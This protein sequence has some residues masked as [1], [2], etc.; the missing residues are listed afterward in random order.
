MTLNGNA[1][2]NLEIFQT[3][4]LNS[5][6]DATLGCGNWK[7]TTGSLMNFMDKTSTP[8]GQR[9]LRKWLGMPLTDDIM[10]EKRLESV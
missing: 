3:A 1:L 7:S 10:I 9:L 6:F 8:Y 4:S 5:T 2:E